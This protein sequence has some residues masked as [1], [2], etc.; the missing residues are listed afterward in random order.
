MDGHYRM[1]VKLLRIEISNWVFS[2]TEDFQIFHGLQ[3]LIQ[4]ITGV[5]ETTWFSLLG[6]S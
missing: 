1:V 3:F 4:S 6:Q 2:N 5:I